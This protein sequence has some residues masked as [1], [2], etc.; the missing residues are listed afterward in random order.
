MIRS[1]LIAFLTATAVSA[2][3]QVIYFLG[4]E[5][6]YISRLKEEANLATDDSA[7]A[8]M[9]LNL[10]LLYRRV[11]D[12]TQSKYYLK[13]GVS[14][15]KNNPF[16][17]SA[18]QY[19]TALIEYASK[20]LGM[21]EKKLK[22][23]DSLLL[24]YTS[25]ASYRLRGI[26]WHNLGILEQIKGNEAGAM[27]AFTEH[28]APYGGKSGDNL[29]AGKAFKA[30]AIIFMNT[31]RRAKAASYL[32]RAMK[33]IEYSDLDNPLNRV[34][35]IETYI[36]AGENYVYMDHL[37]SASN[38]LKKAGQYLSP[39]P[40][41][42]LHLIYY[43]AMGIYYHKIK[44]YNKSLAETEKGIAFAARLNAHH[45]LN[46][47]RYAQY[48]TLYDR[49]QFQKAAATLEVLNQS[50]LVF[51]TDR[52]IYY[53]EL[54]EVYSRLRS[55]DKALLYA[56][57][58]I[59]LSDSLY[60]VEFQRDIIE[61]EEKYN[62]SENQ[63]KIDQLKAEREKAELNARNKTLVNWLLGSA[64]LGLLVLVLL[65][66]VLYRNARKLASQKETHYQQQLR[67][68]EQQQRI[69]LTK[70]LMEGEEKERKRLAVDL[71]DGLGGQLA[72]IKMNLSRWLTDSSRA[73]IEL[74]RVTYQLDTATQELRRIARNMMPESLLRLGLESALKDLCDALNND[75][76]SIAFQSFDISHSIVP[77]IQF[78]IYRIIQ[79]LLSN[80][81][82][83]ASASNVLVQCSQNE[84]RFFIT[85]EDNGKGFDL[86][87]VKPHSGIG[88]SNVKNRV[89]FL[90][91]KLEIH[92]SP[93]EGT[94]I[95]IEFS[96]HEE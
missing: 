59:A 32:D 6:G 7:K 65:S 40:A 64:T 54:F 67:E 87:A 4:N 19:H 78:N 9:Y 33:A 90:K 62:R 27:N 31:N 51:T 52:K 75:Q 74:Q 83:H 70:A 24:P 82:R 85:V 21:L 84:S 79:E 8:S 69:R 93:E 50:P 34:E 48:K 29:V 95:N 55:A 58:Y 94:T 46:R 49:G 41:S 81:L 30:I 5:S 28:A 35:L 80:A 22:Q 36:V 61:L 3:G 38:A 42:N 73:D 12:T 20:D 57:R 45:A 77:D 10:A 68:A 15:A 60:E 53:K 25:A 14:L 91:G 17:R 96:I 26:I 63:K 2:N 92:S 88:L 11:S 23:T 13:Q 37:D 71:H 1:M 89:E 43:Y 66:V 16:L 56:R 47:L 76:I 18:A 39:Y 72:G 44:D 86:D